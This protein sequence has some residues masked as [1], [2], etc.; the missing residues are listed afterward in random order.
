M[1]SQHT[2][3]IAALS[4]SSCGTYLASAGVDG[5]LVIWFVKTGIA[6]HVV[7]GDAGMLSIAWVTSSQSQNLLCGVADGTVISVIFNSNGANPHTQDLSATGYKA[8]R[9]PVEHLA[10]KHSQVAT[11]ALHQVFLWDHNGDEWHREASYDAPLSDGANAKSEVIITGLHWMQTKE[12]QSTLAVSYLHHDFGMLLH[13]LGFDAYRS[14]PLCRAS[15]TIS[16]D[17]R[18]LAVSN[19]THGFDLYNLET[20]AI[21]GRVFNEIGTGRIVPVLFIHHGCTVIGGSATGTAYLHID[22]VQ[23][24]FLIATGM[25]GRSATYIQL[26]EAEDICMP[27]VFCTR[28]S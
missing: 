4:F 3:T 25:E 16:P 21:E 24:E 20:Y 13:I 23:D 11:G 28:K 22:P 1:A 26:W 7:C 5:K 17:H 19:M 2:G 8:H 14:L 9:Y 18:L 15:T 6:L 27:T 12:C 10:I